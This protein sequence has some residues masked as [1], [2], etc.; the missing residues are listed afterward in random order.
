MLDKGLLNLTF[1]TLYSPG[2]SSD[3]NSVRGFLDPIANLDN[4]ENF[5]CCREAKPGS[6]SRW[7]SLNTDENLIENIMNLATKLLFHIYRFSYQYLRA[8]LI[9]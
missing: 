6:F 1:R 8:F 9:F 3:T 7:H 2:S 4:L 5:L